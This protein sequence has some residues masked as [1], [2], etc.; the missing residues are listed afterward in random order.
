MTI[1][2]KL[3]AEIQRM[4]RERDRDVKEGIRKLH[5]IVRQYPLREFL[6]LIS[7]FL[8][9]GNNASR[10]LDEQIGDA[11]EI[12]MTY[13]IYLPTLAKFAILNS[14]DFIG[15]S[16]L[17]FLKAFDDVK[18]CIIIINDIKDNIPYDFADNFDFILAAFQFQLSNQQFRFQEN[19]EVLKNTVIRSLILFRELPE[20]KYRTLDIKR[21]FNDIYGMPFRKFWIITMRLPLMLNGN[22]FSIKDFLGLN[23]NPYNITEKDIQNYLKYLSAN[24]TKFKGLAQDP[25]KS[26]VGQSVQIYGYT[27]LD[28]HPIIKC[29]DQFIIISPHYLLW[30]AF[31]P[32]YFDL[33]QYFQEGDDPRRNRFSSTF[34]FI[35]Q[36][37][38]GLQIEQM[39]DN[40]EIV[41]EIKYDRNN[42]DFV[43]WSLLYGKHAILMEVKKNLLPLKAKFILDKSLLIEKLIATYVKGFKQISSKIKHAQNRI[44]GLEKFRDVEEFYPIVITFD[45]TYLM[46]SHFIRSMID[47]E[48]KKEN[49]KFKNEWQILTIRELEEV[50]SICDRENQFIE[51][52][53]KKLQ[54]DKHCNLEWHKF[55]RE[56]GFD[57][58]GNELLSQTFQKEI[59]V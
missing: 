13:Q 52:L 50:V 26:F 16:N 21:A 24:Y 9:T 59:E 10:Y 7:S 22:W 49:I 44:K 48:L 46:N 41:P 8:W 40:A 19:L 36:D 23:N 20:S 55:L 5:S 54:N 14:N 17:P 30:R 42:K 11:K 31:L 43:D 57:H 35:F 33:L 27:P 34:G 3:Q 51:I 28:S 47:A 38:V 12:G 58:K 45:D 32:V 53:R 4:K 18:Q 25:E 39:K 1:N 37:Y 29:K 15:T 6:F 56:L 2:K